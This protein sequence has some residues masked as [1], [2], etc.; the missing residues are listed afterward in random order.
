MP[1]AASRLSFLL[2]VL[3]CGLGA[4]ALSVLPA[5]AQDA[6]SGAAELRQRHAALRAELASNAFGEPL[7]VTSIV[8]GERVDGEVH[9]EIAHPFPAISLA[10]K[11]GTQVCE[12]LL[13]H[14]N[15]R[16]CRA[17]AAG[18][19]E[20]IELAVGPKQRST[21]TPIRSLN[22]RLHIDVDSGD[23][24]RATLSTETGPLSTAG[25]RL[26]IEAVPMDERRAFVRVR[27]S[28]GS[29]AL[30]KLAMKVYLATAG[31]SKIGFTVTGKAQDGSPLYVGGERGALERNAMRYYLAVRAFAAIQGASSPATTEARQRT[32]FE[33]TERYAAQLHELTL[34]EYLDEKRRDLRDPLP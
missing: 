13:L 25:N 3:R 2:I 21:I 6:S 23:Y 33:L 32:W 1:S 18:A 10:F 19:D 17:T 22:Y 14:L 4:L 28:Y 8:N 11:S 27:Y 34:Q 9:A 30:T 29:S 24:L 16:G 31:R 12:V 20:S 26:V 7:T 5:A 15:V